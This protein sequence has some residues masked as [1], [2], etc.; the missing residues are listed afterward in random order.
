MPIFGRKKPNAGSPR[1]QH[2]PEKLDVGDSADVQWIKQSG[3]PKVWHDAALTCLIFRGDPH[4]L[5]AWLV[6]QPA[7]DRV[8]A[9]AIFLH[10]DN[11]VRRLSGEDVEFVGK[12]DDAEVYRRKRQVEQAIDRLCDLDGSRTLAD[13]GIGMAEG[14]EKARL[15]ALAALTGKARAPLRL[16]QSPIDRQTAAMPYT[17][18]GEG[19]LVTDAYLR[20]EMPFLFS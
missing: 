20:R 14:W 2:Y 17:D 9:A 12:G 18:M 10:G 13:N 16:L 4:D 11:G 7:L 3:D 5:I 1:G 8:T 19:E 6:E 15:V